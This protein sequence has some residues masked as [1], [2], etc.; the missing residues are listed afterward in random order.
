ML[1]QGGRWRFD[2]LPFVEEVVMQDDETQIERQE[3][4]IPIL[5]SLLFLLIAEIVRIALGVTVFFALAWTLVTKCPPSERVRHFANRTLS[6]QYRLLRSLTYNNPP[7][8]FPFSD[9]PPEV[10]PLGPLHRDAA[11]PGGPLEPRVS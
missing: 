11:Q 1:Q 8:P 7:R 3:T 6:Y 9:F 5:L 4:G 10:E 2:S